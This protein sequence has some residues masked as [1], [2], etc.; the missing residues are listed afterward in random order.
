MGN[1]FI[2]MQKSVPIWGAF[3]FFRRICSM[4]RWTQVAGYAILRKFTPFS[5]ILQ[6]NFGPVFLQ[7]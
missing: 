7:K 4:H 5:A 2:P 1:P 3:L 6:N